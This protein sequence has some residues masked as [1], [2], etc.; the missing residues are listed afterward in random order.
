M[1]GKLGQTAGAAAQPAQGWGFGNG[2]ACGRAEAGAARSSLDQS[3]LNARRSRHSR[4]PDC[5][6][7][8]SFPCRGPH[9]FAEKARQNTPTNQMTEIG[10]SPKPIIDRIGVG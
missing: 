1:P 6:R 4:L 7:P 9:L 2:V 10:D 3:W 8:C 5:N